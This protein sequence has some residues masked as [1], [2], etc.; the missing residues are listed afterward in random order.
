MEFYACNPGLNEFRFCPRQW[1]A[2]WPKIEDR[3]DP[4][5]AEITIDS[6]VPIQQYAIIRMADHGRT[7]FR[8][9][10]EYPPEEDGT[11]RHLQ[12]AGMEKLLNARILPWY[13][14]P[15]GD[16]TMQQLFANT[17]TSDQ[18]P[19][20]LALIN[21]HVPPGTDYEIYDS[22]KNIVKLHGW[23]YNGK[24]GRR[25][26]FICYT[27]LTQL[28]EVE[29]LADLQN[30]DRGY[31]RDADDLYIRIYNLWAKGWPDVGGLILQDC[32]DTTVRVRNI[33]NS[34]GA[35]RGDLQIDWDTEP[36]DLIVNIAKGHGYYLH[37][38]DDGAFTYLDITDEEGRGA[39]EGIF[40]LHESQC[41]KWK[42]K[43]AKDPRPHA[44]MGIGE[45][46]QLYTK[47]DL[48]APGVW[49]V[50]RYEVAHGFKDTEG[51]LISF[52]D[53]QYQALQT[54]YSWEVSTYNRLILNPGD[55]I[56]AES[57][58]GHDILTCNKITRSESGE[59]ELVLGKPRPRFVDSWSAL[60]GMTGGFTDH[61]LWSSNVSTTIQDTEFYPY[62]PTHS[63][64]AADMSF[65]APS[66]CKDSS[67]IPRITMDLSLNY[68]TSDKVPT[69]QRVVFQ[70][71]IN[72]QWFATGGFLITT[73]GVTLP[74]MDITSKV[75]A[76]ASNN[77]KVYV[78]FAKD[79][80]DTHSDYTG[81]PAMSASATINYWRRMKPA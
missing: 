23:G 40:T 45:G 34:G 70:V 74:S 64:V 12:V 41:K 52:T 22:D 16:V 21:G 17:P 53:A 18:V 51:F 2:S 68:N 35:L 55:F 15:A 44:L 37:V 63:G 58:F 79:V 62:D 6:K 67:L 25:A 19:G 39:G 29:Y 80:S 11:K 71:N 1:Q 81:H 47:L 36:G 26:I 75:N 78:R 10:V 31:Y 3:L 9:Y 57:R 30:V 32:M 46:S 5:E 48:T 76:G 33:S 77:V 69:S 13:Y 54:D 27:T 61:S 59:T 14:Y 60:Q 50:S 38:S 24:G 65:T 4:R 73:P 7:V 66:G 72:D 20:L 28:G 42:K 43:S 8:G 49:F 56:R